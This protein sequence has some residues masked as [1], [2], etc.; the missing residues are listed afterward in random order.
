MNTSAEVTLVLR[1]RNAALCQAWTRHLGDLPHVEIGQGDIFEESA[2]ALVSPA[3][4]F[5]YMDGG[6]DAVYLG[7]FGEGLQH[8]LQ[9]VLKEEH[10]GE[11]PVG[12]AVIVPTFDLDMPWLVSAPTMRVPMSVSETVNAYLALRAALFAVMEH[13]ACGQPKIGRVLCPGLA[14]AIGQLAPER[15]A[16]QMRLAYE[17]TLGG[18]RWPPLSAGEVLQTHADL[19][20]S[21]KPS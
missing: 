10:H 20:R 15:C 3:N 8:R 6:I 14:T 1:D 9:K 21:A 2:N 18:R 19:T 12:Q 7:R 17:V 4:S 5:G 13:N 11:L 16:K